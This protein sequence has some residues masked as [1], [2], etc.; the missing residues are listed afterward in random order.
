LR[1]TADELRTLLQ[2]NPDQ[3]KQKALTPQHKPTQ[4]RRSA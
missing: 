1:R 3:T 4:R 2:P